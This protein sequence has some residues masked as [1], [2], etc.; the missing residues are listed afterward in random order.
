[1]V[2]KVSSH[3]RGKEQVKLNTANTTFDRRFSFF[4]CTKRTCLCNILRMFVA[5]IYPGG[6]PYVSN[7]RS[8][9]FWQKIL[10]FWLTRLSNFIGPFLL[11]RH[12][13]IIIRP[14]EIFIIISGLGMGFN[15]CKN[16]NNGAKFLLIDIGI[17]LCWKYSI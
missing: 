10:P 13:S 1:M 14:K 7:G 16:K 5:K 11:A 3:Y 9:I 2:I 12:S 6:A 15:K 4:P 8:D 17:S